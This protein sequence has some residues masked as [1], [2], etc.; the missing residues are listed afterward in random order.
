MAAKGIDLI[1][2]MSM[3]RWASL[4]VLRYI[5]DAP[6]KAIT[7]KFRLAS[8]GQDTSSIAGAFNAALASL[9][10]DVEALSENCAGVSLAL[11]SNLRSD[12]EVLLR[13]ESLELHATPASYVQN[14][15]SHAVHRI[16]SDGLGVQ[17]Q[18][19]H[20]HCGWHFS[21]CQYVRLKSLDGILWSSICDKCLPV[22]RREERERAYLCESEAE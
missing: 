7:D 21:G 22:E 1:A 16:I 9:E 2:I 15:A 18:A 5:K 6:V 20:T 19:W 11:A 13:M 8:V 14:M 4:I 12:Q 10:C 17:C 3:A